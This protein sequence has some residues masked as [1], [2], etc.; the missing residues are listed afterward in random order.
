M[1]P[2][3]YRGM[4]FTPRLSAAVLA[5]VLSAG[6]GGGGGTTSAIPKLSAAK[7]SRDVI[8]HIVVIVQENRSFDNLFQGYP[9]ADTVASGKDSNG[10][11]IQLQPLSMAAGFD[12]NHL[13]SDFVGSLDNGKMDGFDHVGSFPSN[14]PNIAYSY[15]PRS[16]A[17]PYFD[18][19]SK[20]ALADRMFQSNNSASYPA[21]QYVIAAQ[22]A[23]V[24][25]VPS[26]FPWGCDAPAGTTV[27]MLQPDGTTYQSTQAP[28]FDYQT[29]AD[30]MDPA[31][32]SWSYYS[33]QIG[34]TGD[35]A[36]S[37]W[38][39]YDAIR[40]IRYG[41]DWARNEIA[42]ETSI[43]NVIASGTLRSVSFVTPDA[44]NSDHAR[45]PSTSG[46]AWVSSIVSAIGASQYWQDTAIFVTWDDWGGWYD[47][48]VP[49]KIDRNGPGFR[50]PLLLISPYAKHGYVSHVQYE[51]SSITRYIEDCF[52]LPN[53]GQRDATATPPD[54]MFDYNQTV[55]PLSGVR[56]SQSVLRAASVRAPSHL[57]P[58]DD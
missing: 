54:D 15:V 42:P 35:L 37:L 14:Q 1:H 3:D 44:L 9:G 12:P 19:A 6:C 23:N 56:L 33:P 39:P 51:T 13:Y 57:V 30:L 38:T 28:C 20:Y 45:F 18:L 41:S 52:G 11:T 16:E 10:R 5:L 32:V 58:D 24:T 2:V 21:H 43:L 36:G 25:N 17:Q 27:T 4:T 50:V 34:K 55:A 49:P 8:K 29:L 31:G 53:L 47:H 26:S 48:V 7:H 40:H 46:P 22:S